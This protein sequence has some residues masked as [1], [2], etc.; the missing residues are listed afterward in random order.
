MAG[1]GLEPERHTWVVLCH[2]LVEETL[3]LHREALAARVTVY[4]PATFVGLLGVSAQTQLPHYTVEG[5]PDIVLH[6]C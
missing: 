4:V 2:D 3:G 6:G 5:L 1:L